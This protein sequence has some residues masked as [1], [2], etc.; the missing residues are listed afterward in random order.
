MKKPDQTR[1]SS[2]SYRENIAPETLHS[3]SIGCMSGLV[4]LVSKYH[5]R[6]KFL[7]FGKK[8]EKINAVSSPAKP[9]PS[10]VSTTQASPSVVLQEQSAKEGE[11]AAV[12]LRKLSCDMQRSPTLPAEMRRSKSSNSR[13]H[14]RNPPALMARL[15]GLEG[16]PESAA[17]KR[18]KLLGALEKCNEDL[19]ALRKIIESVQFSERL[20]STDAGQPVDGETNRLKRCSEFNNGEQQ[21]PSPVSVLDEF[22]PSPSSTTG[23][24][25]HSRRHANGSRLVQQQH[26]KQLRKKPGEEETTKIYFHDRINIIST[27]ETVERK[28]SDNVVGSIISSIWSSKAMIESVEEVCRDIDWGKRREIGRIGLA[29]QDHICRDLIEEMVGEMQQGCCCM[30]QYALPLEACKRRLCF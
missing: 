11:D 13:Q 24:Y 28:G 16:M 8:Q 1:L 6:R 25:C 22:T 7:T 12:D 30:L 2:S 23:Q 15:M 9:K 10:S 27:T 26:Q 3:K 21:Q 18:R 4:N 14:F 19:N 5:N 29:L 20:K 17:E